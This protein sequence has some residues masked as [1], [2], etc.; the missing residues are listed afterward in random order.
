MTTATQ[1]KDTAPSKARHAEI[2]IIGSG[3]AGLGA[4]IK[5]NEAGHTD[6][7]VLERGEEVGGTWRDNS[8][9]GAACDVPSQL[10]SYSFALNPDWSRSFSKQP[11]I[12]A[13]IRN[14]A[15]ASG[16]LDR[17]LF[18]TELLGARWDAAAAL[19]RITTNQGEFTAS[20]VIP[21]VGALCEPALPDIKGI[22]DFEGEIFHSS[23]WNHDVDL[24]GKRVAVIGTGASSIQIVPAIAGKVSHLDV[25]QRTAPWILPRAD[26]E[27]SAVERFAYKHVPGFQR[28]ARAGVYALRETQV[29]GLTKLPA[30]LKPL[31]LSA[32]MHL[33]KAIKDPVLRA[34]VTP[35]FSMGCKRMLISNNYYPALAQPNVDVV[36]DPISE[37]RAGSIVTKDGTV[38]EIDALIVATGFHVTDSPVFEV[39]RGKTGTTL[40]ETWDRIGM[41]GYKGTAVADFPNMFFLVGP[42][43][44]LGHSS[45]VYM[46]ESQITYAVEAVATLK[47]HGLSSV[48]VRGDVSADFNRE[49]QERL[50]PTVWMTGGCASWYLDKHGNNTTLWPG[51]TFEFRKLTKKFDLDAYHATSRRDLAT[52]TKTALEGSAS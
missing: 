41:Q 14:V 27:Y 18:S 8:Y 52:S 7:L 10:Y 49:L 51:H 35:N 50:K 4:A 39:I 42:N 40:S 38:R 37:V 19:W 17:H 12:Q 32:T 25:Y 47:R 29:V 11:E 22:G 9:P 2:I 45:M 1:P 23:R 16:V 34:K 26:R 30:L 43:T 5:L 48:E 15:A 33:R 36:T 3:F 13:Y 28:L 21:A 44:G 46:I 20:I 31:Q 24:T 6:F